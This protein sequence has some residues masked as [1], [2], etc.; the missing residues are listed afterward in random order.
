[1]AGGWATRKE[2]FR[3]L[4]FRLLLVGLVA[5]LLLSFVKAGGTASAAPARAGVNENW[6]L[7]SSDRDGKARMYSVGEDGSRLSPLFPPG[8]WFA[9][10]AVSRDGSTIAYVADPERYVPAGI[11][12]SRADG[13]GFHRLVRKG[14]D[15]AFSPD[16]RLLAFT[17]SRGIWIVGIDGHG[18]RRLTSQDDKA[19][20]W[21]PDGKALVFVRSIAKDVYGGGRY[22][23]VV[24]PL[25]GRARVIVRIGKNEDD[26]QEL[27]QP[28]WSPSGRWIAYFN[29]ENDSRKNG[30]TVVRPNGKRRHRV[31]LG[32][33]DVLNGGGDEPTFG[34]SPDG[35]GLAFEVGS[36]LDYI[37]PSGKNRKISAQAEGPVVWSTDGKRLAFAL[38]TGGSSD[39]A[40]AR[41]DGRGLRR[42][43]L[44]VGVSSV[45]LTWSPD[46]SRIAFGGSAGD[47]LQIW[48]V[49]SDGQG[50]R[51]LTS[52][53]SN[54]PVGWTRLA[55]VLP[56]APPIPPTEHVLDARTVA[57]SSP[58]SALSADGSR[59]T[60]A[61]R[62]GMTDCE[63]VVAWAPGS[64][65]IRLGK[66]PAP[67]PR[68]DGAITSL[69]LA[70][71][72]AAW[73]STSG[74]ED[75]CGFALMSATLADPAPRAVNVG[76][77]YGGSCQSRDVDHLRG[78]G[79]LI[80]F[81]DESSHPTW[82]VQIGAGAR[83]CG[84]LVCLTLRKGR[85]AAPVDSVSGALIAVRTHAAV[86]VLDNH[87]ALVRSFPF[88]P[89]DVYS[90]RLDGGRLVVAR[91]YTIESYDVA[92]G[93]QEL[94]R[95][96]PA[97]YELTDVDNGIAVFRRTESV[98]LLRLGDD[99]SLTLTPG[100]GPVLADLEQPGLYYS[101]TTE[102][103]G[104]RVVFVPRAELLQPLGG[105]S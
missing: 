74:G 41:A 51:R 104:G 21:A 68:W 13:S 61:V 76:E 27:Y 88:A 29:V 39:L 91:S 60:F 16:G 101:Y 63:H 62:P 15:P 70:G 22:A 53:G 73:V 8:R 37:L 28:K 6:I 44:G 7:L 90:A 42:L 56:P 96:L 95:P 86:A 30:L 98:I 14:L 77:V 47:P 85:Q 10:V 19:F 4:R 34:W 87:G 97:G 32:A 52:E 66:F 55:P 64:D 40:V 89:A 93:A 105:G 65:L 23:I 79:D 33:G 36:T 20:D 11:Y 38:G 103:G 78:D 5:A 49:G 48:V 57:T 82:L 83:K 26:N 81:N 2:R 31:V 46:S 71:A 58:I 24:Q 59:V 92:T 18:L 3:L 69:A 43:H 84:E 75:S 45:G 100:Q 9:P 94:S 17:T 72:R 50:L 54:S 12:L 99:A 102:D 1:M 67:C 35:R 25:R 80:V